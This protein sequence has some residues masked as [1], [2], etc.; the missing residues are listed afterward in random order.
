MT[1]KRSFY[2]NNLFLH[3]SGPLP[4]LELLS[5]KSKLSFIK[6]PRVYGSGQFFPAYLNC[7][8]VL[9]S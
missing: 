1:E 6:L 9:L 5:P 7:A 4:G 3:P 2:P 8:V